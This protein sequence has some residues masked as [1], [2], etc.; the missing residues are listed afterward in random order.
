MSRRWLSWLLWSAT[1][2][3]LGGGL[4]LAVRNGSLS[5]DPTFAVFAIA[6]LLGYASIGALVASRLPNSPIGW[7]MLSGGIGFMVSFSSSDYARYALYTNPGSLP[8]A[9]LAVWLQTWIF[10]VPVGAIVLLVSLFPSGSAASPRWRW[11]PYTIVGTF[12]VAIVSSMFRVGPVD[13]TDVAGIPDP[14]N[15]LGIQALDPVLQV[16]QLVAGFAALAAAVLAVVSLVMRYRAARGDERQQEG[17]RPLEFG[18]LDVRRGLRPASLAEAHGGCRQRRRRGRHGHDRRDIGGHGRVHDRDAR[19]ALVLEHQLASSASCR[20]RPASSSA[21]G[22]SWWRM[23]S[24]VRAE[25]PARPAMR[26]E[27]SA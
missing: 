12:A 1:I 25:Q 16:I 15:P 7:L 11:L 17:Q 8:F 23:S 10:L 22:A 5:E 14:Q 19:R 27:V 4:T 2:V 9:S 24:T 18:D 26:A 3:L 13:F 6:M 20:S 21:S